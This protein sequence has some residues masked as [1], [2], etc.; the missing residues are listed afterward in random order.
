MVKFYTTLLNLLI[1]QNFLLLPKA[2]QLPVIDRS[3]STLKS[4]FNELMKSGSEGELFREYFVQ[5]KSLTK[6]FNFSEYD[7]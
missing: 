7:P 2:L 5:T 6:K 4:R 3:E 1:L